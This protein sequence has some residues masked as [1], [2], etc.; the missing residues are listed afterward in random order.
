[1]SSA[2]RCRRPEASGTHFL[3]AGDSS[4]LDALEA[5]LADLPP[6]AYG[7]AFIEIASHDEA[8]P[9]ST[10]DGIGV[11][12][13]CRDRAVDRTGG[14]MPRGALLVRA[15]L[16][17]VAEWMPARGSRAGRPTVMWIGC[18]ANDRVDRLYEN[19][20]FRFDWI[21]LQSPSER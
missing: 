11:V 8:R 9:L 2:D 17:W 21:E 4:D 7:Q 5:V 1:M 12:W 13:L 10:R 20:A 3:L 19:L 16:G 14:W 6:D 18:E 15:V